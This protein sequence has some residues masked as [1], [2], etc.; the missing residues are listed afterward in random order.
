LVVLCYCEFDALTYYSGVVLRY[1]E[2]YEDAM[3]LKM[4]LLLEKFGFVAGSLLKLSGL[5]EVL[6]QW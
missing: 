2:D 4:V 6:R 5:F 3:S 1:S